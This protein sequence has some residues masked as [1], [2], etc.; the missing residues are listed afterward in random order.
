MYRRE[1]YPHTY[2]PTKD[3]SKAGNAGTRTLGGSSINDNNFGLS[4]WWICPEVCGA[5]LRQAGILAQQSVMFS[6]TGRYMGPSCDAAVCQ[7]GILAY[8]P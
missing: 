6:M 8:R 4:V 5:I 7:A 2:L 3:I 1:P